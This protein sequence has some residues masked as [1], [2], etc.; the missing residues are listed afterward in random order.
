MQ[1][2]GT[3]LS[4]ALKNYKKSTPKKILIFRE[5]ELCRFRLKKLLGGNLESRKTNKRSTMKKVLVSYDDF[6]V[7]KAVK[8]REIHCK[9]KLQ[10]VDITL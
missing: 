3:L 6:T 4:P 8:H 1:L 7:I 9:A 10:Q 2:A 5:M